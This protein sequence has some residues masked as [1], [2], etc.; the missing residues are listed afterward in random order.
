M[1]K[2]KIV[3]NGQGGYF[4]CALL[5]VSIIDFWLQNK[6]IELL[7]EYI[8]AHYL[9]DEDIDEE[10]RIPSNYRFNIFN[11]INSVCLWET[12]SIELSNSTICDIYELNQN[13]SNSFAFIQESDFNEQKLIDSFICTDQMIFKKNNNW[14][15]LVFNGLDIKKNREAYLVYF[16]ANARGYASHDEILVLNDKINKQKLKFYTSTFGINDFS[17]DIIKKALYNPNSKN[18]SVLYD[19][20]MFRDAREKPDFDLTGLQKVSLENNNITFK[21]IN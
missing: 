21:W 9:N 7:Q 1:Y 14:N 10:W 15:D 6:S 11:N 16:K 8:L 5:D 4:F 18:E 20:Q 19:F 13:T 12:D 2:Y 3:L 17:C